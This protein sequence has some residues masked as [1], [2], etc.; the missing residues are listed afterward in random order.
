[1]NKKTAIVAITNN[2]VKLGQQLA[3]L[4]PESHLYVPD[5][6]ACEQKERVCTFQGAIGETIKK[7]FGKYESLILI[8]AMG[9]AV[10]VIASEIKD[11]HQDPAI[12]VIDEKGTFVVS[13]LSGHIGGANEL[14]KRIASSI[15]AH[16]VI[17]TASDLN[18]T[19]AVDLLG[20]EF[21]WELDN[22]ANVTMVSTA[23]VN[24]EKIGIY[25]DAGEQNWWAKAKPLPSNIHIFASLEA[26]KEA[27]CS[28]ALIITDHVLS[29]EYQEFLGR[30][31]LYR[32]KS[33]VIGI[34]CNKGISCHR[35]EEAITQV[36][37]EHGLSMKSIR[38]LATIDLKRHEQG[39]LEFALKYNLPMEFFPR[40]NLEQVGFPSNPSSVA[41]KY[42]GVHAVCEPSAL[43][44]SENTS[45]I[46]PKVKLGDITISVAR[47]SYTER[48]SGK[49]AGNQIGKLFI[50]GLGP[51]DSEHLTFEAKEI[52][53]NSDVIVGYRTYV[54]MIKDMVG[55]KQVI[56]TGMGEEIKR[57]SE[58]VSLACAGK[59]VSLVSSGDPGIYGM[60]GL[61]MELLRSKDYPHAADL[62]VQVIPGVPAFSAAS[63]LLGAPLMHDFASI[64]LSDLLTPW[65]VIALR[66][67]M[68]A[69]GNFVIALYN[70]RSKKR[71]RQLI[72]AREILLK[73]RSSSTPVG[74]VD[75]AHHDKQKVNITDLEYMLDFDIGMS[76]TIIVGNSTTFTFNEW[77]VTPRGYDAKYRLGSDT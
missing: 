20:K 4:F 36:F 31:V 49:E 68:A 2:G 1:M 44:S 69:K 66:L 7:I 34:G 62:Q 45:L 75:N 61:V 73:Y 64:S 5:K 72:E 10:R 28:A 35:I 6:F 32:P 67:H 42:V 70:P 43:L 41:F 23:L 33:L 3:Y 76:T 37:R 60:A 63:A 56:A 53:T 25:Q 39:L 18:E 27:S 47:L 74:I 65:K 26:L 19:I 15:G 16:P 71:Q 55:S 14:T 51:G 24:G 29:R 22:I 8:M 48:K 11:K 59:T 17:T 46:V 52:I 50:V 58:A 9:I 54:R 77:M 12:V 13:L 21:G 40:E 57:A 30:A 38:N